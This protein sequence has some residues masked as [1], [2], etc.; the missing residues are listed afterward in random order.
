M[1]NCSDVEI[2]LVDDNPN[3]AENAIQIVKQNNIANRILVIGNGEE[4][5]DYLF[6]RGIYREQ[7]S[8]NRPRIVLLSLQLAKINGLEVLRAL[9]SDRRTKILPVVLLVSSIEEKQKVED[10]HPG[11]NSYIIKPVDFEKLVNAT[12]DLGLHILFLN[13]P[14]KE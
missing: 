9:R 13:Q 3:D 11:V 5:L 10:K 8:E 2:L 4:A 12:R 14:P 6:A 7:K 1:T